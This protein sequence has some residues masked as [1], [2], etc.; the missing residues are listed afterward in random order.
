MKRRLVVAAALIK[1]TFTLPTVNADGTP[2]TDIARVRLVATKCDTSRVLYDY[3]LPAIAPGVPWTVTLN[4][5][6]D[7]SAAVY[8]LTIDRAGN[9]SAPSNRIVPW[10]APGGAQ[11]WKQER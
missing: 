10:P 4:M 7:S 1:L 8:V 2:C 9:I 11:E 3:R 5:P 6:A